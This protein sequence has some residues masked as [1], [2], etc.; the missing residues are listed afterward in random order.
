[1]KSSSKKLCSTT[2]VSRRQ[3]ITVG[4]IEKSQSK[5][6]SVF[7]YLRLAGMHLVL[8]NVSRLNI[9]LITGLQ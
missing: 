9:I 4:A 7:C 3:E 2:K 6:L 5:N 1:M 8:I